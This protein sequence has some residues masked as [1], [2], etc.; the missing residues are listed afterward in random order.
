MLTGQDESLHV[1]IKQYASHNTPLPG[2]RPIGVNQAYG[3]TS[4]IPLYTS[5]RSR[6]LAEYAAPWCRA[7]YDLDPGLCDFTARLRLAR[8]D[9]PGT[10]TCCTNE[11]KF[12]RP[13]S[14]Q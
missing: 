10:F 2:V 11:V 4:S 5:D 8:T 12:R 6:V 14:R 9:G 1:L 7:L 3:G 13:R